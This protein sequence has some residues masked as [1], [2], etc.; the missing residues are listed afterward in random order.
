MSTMLQF[1]LV[2]SLLTVTF[3]VVGAASLR[4]GARRVRRALTARVRPALAAH[5]GVSRQGAQALLHVRALV[6]GPGRAV[7]LARRDLLVDLTGTVRAVRAG[8]QAGRPVEGLEFIV[9]RLSEQARA[10]DVDLAVI[11]AEPDR[12]AQRMLLAEQADRLILLRRAFGQIRRGVLLAGSN[13]T[14]PVL[15]SMID[16]LSDEVIALGLRAQAHRE[17]AGR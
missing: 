13:A 9:R 16:E 15:S 4:W 12:A 7:A 11:A 3:V 10:A 14:A 5:Q 8:R 6:P 1:L 2:W 17:L